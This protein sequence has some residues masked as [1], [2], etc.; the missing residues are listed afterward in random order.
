VATATAAPAARS[1]GRPV[2]EARPESETSVVVGAVPAVQ[3]ERAVRRMRLSPALVALVLVLL[4]AGGLLVTSWVIWQREPDRRPA[5]PG[6]APAS[7]AVATT[8]T[9]PATGF[10]PVAC[11]RPPG[12][13][14]PHTPQPGAARRAKGFDLLPSWSEYMD[15]TGFKVAVPDGWSYERIGTTVCFRDP[16]NVRFLAVDPARKPS[17]DPVRACDTEA[18]RLIRAGDLPQYQRISLDRAPLQIT[19]ADWEYA[20]T[21]PGGMRMH[22]KTRWFKSGDHAYALSWATRDLDWQINTPYFGATIS[23]FSP[24]A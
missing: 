15:S 8:A 14:L 7:S 21:A 18:T 22:A 13:S 19:A 16:G 6:L 5:A 20:W 9:A 1:P 11:T 23:S 2:D 4:L 3:S 12:P 17:A 10:T 24:I